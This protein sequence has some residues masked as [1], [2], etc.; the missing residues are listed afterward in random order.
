VLGLIKE[1]IAAQLVVEATDGHFAFRHALTRQAIY[2]AL[3]A[4]ERKALHK[5]IAETMER[6]HVGSLDVPLE[7]LAYHLHAAELW[8]KALE[9]GQRAGERAQALSAPRSAIAQYT[10]A[11]EAAQH[12]TDTAPRALLRERGQA[13]QTIGEFA[14]ARDD[15][16]ATLTFARAAAD[17]RGEWQ[18][19]LD[20]GFL[21]SGH[22]YTLAGD[23]LHQALALARELG[24][25]PVLAHT[26]NRLGNWYVNVEQPFV[27]RRYH[28]EALAIFR[29]RDDRRGIAETLDLL[30]LASNMAD[31]LVQ[32]ATSYEEAVVLF[33]ELDDRQGL[34]SSRW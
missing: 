8:P 22:D 21:L 6:L 14:R 19:L 11:L 20:L 23:Y 29:G 3:L 4:R 5:R 10:R 28:E 13:Y 7:D 26:L 1:L 9:Y 34:A 17:R 15:Y 18:A 30:G 25:A 33:H 12:T 24:D 32:S 16:E 2:S 27:G 31:D